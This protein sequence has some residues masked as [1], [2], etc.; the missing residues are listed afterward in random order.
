V[1]SN[2]FTPTSKKEP[3]KMVWRTVRNSLLVGRYGVLDLKK[4]GLGKRRIAAFDLVS[5]N[6]LISLFGLTDGVLLILGA[7]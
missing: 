6:S 2:F 3:E 5:E 4:S 7:S 1:V